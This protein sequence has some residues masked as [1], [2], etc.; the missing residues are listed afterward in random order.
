LVNAN[1]FVGVNFGASQAGVV[2]NVGQAFQPDSPGQSQAG[3]P[4]LQSPPL[5][6]LETTYSMTP[7]SLAPT[8]YQS[9]SPSPSHHG[10]HHASDPLYVLDMNTGETVP[11]NVTLNTFST[12]SENLLAQVSG[13][14]VSSWSWSTTNAPDLTN[15][16]GASTANLQGS[17]TNFTG[18]ARTDT[19]SVTETDTSHRQMTQ[20]MTF[21]V[22][23]T[24]SPAYSSTRPTSS[25]TWPTV[26][27]PDQLSGGQATQAAGPYASIGLADGSVQTSFSMPSYNPNTTPVSLDYNST[28][29]NAQPIFLDEY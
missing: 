25:S 28:A 4:D 15:I 22:A 14:T 13:T 21:E 27:S 9:L 19:L 5:P 11:A 26:I 16:T 17:W 6:A 8:Q 10:H 18:T 2:A 7:P 3:K 29:A 20:T 12:W 23:G 1:Q 24:S